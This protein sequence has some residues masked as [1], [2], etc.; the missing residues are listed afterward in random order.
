MVMFK[1]SKGGI[2]VGMIILLVVF[3]VFLSVGFMLFMAGMGVYNKNVDL[4]TQFNA[5]TKGNTVIYD[6]VWKILQQKAGVTNQS[7]DK[8]KEIYSSIINARYEGKDNVLMNWIQEQNP[9]FDMSLW[10]DLSLSIESQ[11]TEFAVVQ[12]KLIDIKREH[13]LL[14]S[15]FPNNIFCMIL[16]IKELEL[17]LVTSSRTEKA[18]EIGVDDDVELFEKTSTPPVKNTSQTEPKRAKV[19]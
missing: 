16:G 9:T 4:T 17:K 3:G 14:R 7:A 6:K 12:Q 19:L 15:K 1:N 2:G 8:F 13:D 18:F 11:R 5:Q 10:K